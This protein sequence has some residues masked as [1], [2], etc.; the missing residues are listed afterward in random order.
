MVFVISLSLSILLKWQ[1]NI[2]MLKYV[3]KKSGFSKVYL[4]FHMTIKSALATISA[5]KTI[6]TSEDSTQL[7]T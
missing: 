4:F 7:A 3:L 6:V 5:I 1:S 2:C